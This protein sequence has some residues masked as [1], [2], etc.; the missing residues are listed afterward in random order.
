[1]ASP[2]IRKGLIRLSLWEEGR[3]G[4]FGNLG[5]RKGKNFFKGLFGLR[6]E[7]FGHFTTLGLPKKGV[8]KKFLSQ[9]TF[10]IG[11]WL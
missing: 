1:L 8:H 10:L 3:L 2:I 6:K 7:A 11:I 4:E 9:L 5:L